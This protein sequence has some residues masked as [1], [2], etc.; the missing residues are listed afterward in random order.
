MHTL[1]TR[2]GLAHA[3]LRHLQAGFGLAHALLE[4]A[5]TQAHE[6][7]AG[8]DGIAGDDE[9]LLNGPGDAGVDFSLIAGADR[10]REPL[11]EWQAAVDDLDGF[12][13]GKSAVFGIECG[14]RSTGAAAARYQRTRCDQNCATKTGTIR[15]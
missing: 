8:G 4:I 1:Q 15:H 10:A 5:R 3:R 6:R 13:G 14:S 11:F 12:D 7:F 2:L 9:D